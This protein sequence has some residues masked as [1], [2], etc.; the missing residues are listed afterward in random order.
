MYAAQEPEVPTTYAVDG[1]SEGR[2][3]V[4]DVVAEVA[5]SVLVV[6]VVE[7]EFVDTVLDA[8]TVE[9]VVNDDDVLVVA[10]LVVDATLLEMPSVLVVVTLL[11][12]DNVLVTDALLLVVELVVVT[13]LVV[14]PTLLVV[15]E[16]ELVDEERL[17]VVEDTI[18]EVL[19]SAV[20]WY[21][22]TCAASEDWMADKM[23]WSRKL[24]SVV[25]YPEKAFAKTL[26]TVKG[27]KSEGVSRRSTVLRLLAPTT[28]YDP[29]PVVWNSP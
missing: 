5:A 26:A 1:T 23:F 17:L 4:D 24:R 20:A 3:Q 22:A 10:M 9:L 18:E 16:V 13:E 19:G 27:A 25:A 28:E 2:V 8:T 21:A 15:D 11:I 29:L 6:D 12:V 14:R 7:F